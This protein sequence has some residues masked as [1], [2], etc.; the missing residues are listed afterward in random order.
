[1]FIQPIHFQTVNLAY[2]NYTLIISTCVH[3]YYDIDYQTPQNKDIIFV[4]YK[5]KLNF[6]AIIAKITRTTI[7]IV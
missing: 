2:V 1:M 4:F 3:A 7:R 6:N 5:I